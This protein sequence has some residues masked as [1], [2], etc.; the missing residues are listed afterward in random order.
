MGELIKE[1]KIRYLG[2]YEANKEYLHKA[3]AV[4]PVTAIENRYSMMARWHEDIFPVCEEL[5][6]AY[7]AF[8]PLANE[9]LT[10]KYSSDT[11]FE[12]KL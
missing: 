2:V 3:N 4:T 12:G 10:G 11:K 1:G 7:I 8:S 9:F 5:H 6:I